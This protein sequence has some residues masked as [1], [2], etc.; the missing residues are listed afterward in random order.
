MRNEH[1][2]PIKQHHCLLRILHA[3]GVHPFGF[4]EPQI[5]RC[6][7][8]MIQCERNLELPQFS[9][10]GPS[11]PVR[12]WPARSIAGLWLASR[13]LRRALGPCVVCSFPLSS[14]A[15]SVELSSR[16]IIRVSFQLLAVIEEGGQEGEC[17]Q[18]VQSLDGS[19]VL[20]SIRYSSLERDHAIVTLLFTRTVGPRRRLVAYRG[21]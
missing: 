18:R 13:H 21:N 2:L 3:V 5:P 15:D 16:R 4:L 20:V 9:P 8:S 19:L 14:I 17:H 11:A 1:T 6:K 7:V 10:T 12:M